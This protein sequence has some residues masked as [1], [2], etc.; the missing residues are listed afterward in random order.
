VVISDIVEQTAEITA[1]LLRFIRNHPR[2]KELDKKHYIFYMDQ[3]KNFKS[4]LMANYL[5]AELDG[6]IY[7]E[8]RFFTE[9]HG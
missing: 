9:R 7:V 1:Y 3:A 8:W 5:F 4:N 2:F 6:D